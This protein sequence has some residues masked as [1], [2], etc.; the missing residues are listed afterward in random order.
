MIA[1]QEAEPQPVEPER[2]GVD[3]VR[4]LPQPADADG[5]RLLPD[6]APPPRQPGGKVESGGVPPDLDVTERDAQAILARGGA[7]LISNR[8]L[9][10]L[11][12]AKRAYLDAPQP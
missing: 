4:G 6:A 3:G 10:A 11:L 9:G 1:G 2:T 7:R 5:G 8:E 12:L